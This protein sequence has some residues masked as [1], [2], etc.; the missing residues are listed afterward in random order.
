MHRTS[1]AA[2]AAPDS[3]TPMGVPLTKY[4][5]L[6]A[7]APDSTA[8]S[9]ASSCSS[10]QYSG[11]PLTVKPTPAVGMKLHP[12]YMLT[13]STVSSPTIMPVGQ[14]LSGFVPEPAAP[15]PMSTSSPRAAA[16]SAA[17]AAPA[18]MSRGV[19]N[20]GRAVRGG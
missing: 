11:L 18:S 5:T 7:V 10:L 9:A 4:I 13:G 14:L 8:R 17:N 16:R 6:E 19:A 15:L 20:E 2:S 3:T 1:W 12:V